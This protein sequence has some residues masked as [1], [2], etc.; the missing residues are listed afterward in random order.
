[1][2]V[3]FIWGMLMG[4]WIGNFQT[5]QALDIAHRAN[6]QAQHAQTGWVECL[7]ESVKHVEKDIKA[8]AQE[9]KKV[10]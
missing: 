9:V 5:Q 4:Y 10:K 2:L 6:E 3:L 7:A 1:M 8:A